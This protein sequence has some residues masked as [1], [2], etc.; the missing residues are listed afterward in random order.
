MDKSRMYTV[1]SSGC[2]FLAQVSQTEPF[3]TTIHGGMYRKCGLAMHIL[4]HV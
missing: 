4:V 2:I 3:F 1:I